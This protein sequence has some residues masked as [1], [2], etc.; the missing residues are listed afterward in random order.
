MALTKLFVAFA[1]F[2]SSVTFEEQVLMTKDGISST[3]NVSFSTSISH[4]AQ[5]QSNF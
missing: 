1:L 3:W 5:Q 4:A 2:V